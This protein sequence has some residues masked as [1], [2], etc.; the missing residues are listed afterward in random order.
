VESVGLDSPLEKS[1]DPRGQ[2]GSSN[3]NTARQPLAGVVFW[4]AALACLVHFLFNSRYGYFR[5][6][7]YYAA[8][9]QHLAWGY[10][11]HAP[12]VALIARLSRMLLGDSLF[13]LRFLPALS[14]GAKV[15]LAA[16]I[17]RELDGRRFAQLLAAVCILF[18]P[19][20]LTFDNFLS[21]NA[22]EPLFWMLCAAIFLRIVRSRNQRLWLLYGLV[23]GVGL[24]NKHSMLFFGFGM[25]LGMLLT[26]ERRIFRSGQFWLGGLIAFLIAVP[27]FIWEA[28]HA[29][30]TIQ[31]LRTV[32]EI[33]N[34][35]V[36]PAQFILQQG[37]LLSP[38][39][40]PVWLTGLLC[41]FFVPWARRFRVLG[42]AY[43]LTLLLL[44]VL[45]GKIY[46]LAPAYPMLLAVGAIQFERWVELRGWRWLKPATFAPIALAGLTAA[47]LAMPILP[48][49]QAVAYSK[50][51][52]VERVEVERMPRGELPQLFA[53]MFGWQ[54]QAAVIARVYQSLPPEDRAKAGILTWN[55]GEASALDYFGPA[56]GLPRAISG[57]NQYFE[58][59]TQGHT[60]EVMI[61]YGFPPGQEARFREEWGSVQQV[62]TIDS[63]YALPEE[64]NLPV[65][66]CRNPKQPLPQAWPRFRWLG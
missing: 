36:T 20:Y 38:L 17:V 10:V 43:L 7:L 2:Q 12:L 39:E 4:L 9:G 19:I 13:A 3:L 53:D 15:L 64:R 61:V 21:M 14:A 48:V 54:T 27:N 16:W 58:W 1:L 41:L 26:P 28:Q 60:G 52:N 47:P 11:D 18:A 30:P 49:E 63:A 59:G 33:K 37:L 31:L 46:Y 45:K 42:W 23:A 44:V 40:V 35:P 62:A 25:L 32:A 55:Y 51:W 34:A 65:Y 22:F 56:L 5:D 24:L 29:W 50:F 66:I 6:E 8:C 57:H